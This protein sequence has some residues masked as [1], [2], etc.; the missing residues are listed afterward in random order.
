MFA[1]AL[2]RAPND[3]VIHKLI[4]IILITISDMN[5]HSF[6]IGSPGPVREA[7]ILGRL[8]LPLVVDDVAG[9]FAVGGI[10]ED[11]E[12]PFP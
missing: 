10:R 8:R 5:I 4:A 11:R 2:S 6:I 12:R 3:N 1:F 7:V 9:R